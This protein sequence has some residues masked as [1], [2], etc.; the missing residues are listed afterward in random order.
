MSMLNLKGQ[1]YVNR[2]NQGKQFK[3]ILCWRQ[4]SERVVLPLS[5]FVSILSMRTQ[6]KKKPLWSAWEL[7]VQ[8]AEVNI[9]KYIQSSFESSVRQTIPQKS[10]EPAV[11]VLW[12]E[13]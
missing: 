10:S 9:M 11:F 6:K 7:Y 1:G 3:Y 13:M 12:S 2:T 8:G 5:F 4:E